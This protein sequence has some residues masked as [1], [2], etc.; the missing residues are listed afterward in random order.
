MR[1]PAMSF[2]WRK[3]SIFCGDSW[4]W[5]HKTG[6]ALIEEPDLGWLVGISEHDA[7]TFVFALNLDLESVTDVGS[8][9]DPRVRQSIAS[10][11]LRAEG[12]LPA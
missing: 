12:A 1:Y 5:S 3:A 10:A 2:S 8:Q 11:I 6:T 9:V 4:T 7:R